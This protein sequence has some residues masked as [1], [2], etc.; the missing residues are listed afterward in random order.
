MSNAKGEKMISILFYNNTEYSYPTYSISFGSYV[1]PLPLEVFLLM[2]ALSIFPTMV[3]FRMHRKLL[4]SIVYALVMVSMIF[5]LFYFTFEKYRALG[6]FNLSLKFFFNYELLSISA[7]GILALGTSLKIKNLK[8]KLPISF[9]FYCLAIWI[10][11]FFAR[12]LHS[13]ID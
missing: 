2:A 13:V 12:Y 5:M 7:G 3:I 1:P 11:Y 4:L 9:C 8:I 6:S 10:F